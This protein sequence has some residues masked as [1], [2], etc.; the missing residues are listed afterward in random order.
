MVSCTP[1]GDNHEGRRLKSFIQFVFSQA[2][3]TKLN[4]NDGAHP[5]RF[6]NLNQDYLGPKPKD[7][8]RAP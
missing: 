4:L 6:I 3:E 5:S 8:S 2:V 1:A 7:T